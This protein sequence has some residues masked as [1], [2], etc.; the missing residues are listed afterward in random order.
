[1]YVICG[2][3][4]GINI[5]CQNGSCTIPSH[6]PTVIP[7]DGN[8]NMNT[9]PKGRPKKYAEYDQLVASLPTV[10]TKRPKYIRGIGVF[11]GKRDETAWIKI[12]L[13]HGGTYGGK[14]YDAGSSLEI[15]LGNLSSFSWKQLEERHNEMQGRADR[16]EALEDDAPVLFDEWAK[17]WLS[18]SEVRA[19]S[20]GTLKIH[21][22]KHFIPVFG[23]KALSDITLTDING[24]VTK[25]LKSHEPGT[26]KR[27][28]NTL[29]AIFN[30]AIKHEHLEKN[31]CQHVQPI[32]GIVARQ[33]FLDQ[34][35]VLKL[36][37]A[38]EETAV[39]LPDFILWCLHSGMRKGEI[40]ALTWDCVRKVDGDRSIVEVRNSKSDQPRMVVCTRTMKEII[41][42]Q[43]ARKKDG[44]DL[45]FPIAKMTLRRKW[46]KARKK[47]E[48]EDVTIHDLRRTNATQAV[49]AGIDLRTIAGRIGH[50]DLNML[51]KHYAALVGSASEG[52]AAKIQ[53]MFDGMM[54][55]KGQQ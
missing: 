55:N 18:R 53:D 40:V 17:N 3:G 21:V 14:R 20:P 22:E 34:E 6:I 54:N 27:Q 52:A 29:R 50:K 16:N 2:D 10:M 25:K 24:F 13:P 31:P 32:R 28:F 1:M 48:L 7:T 51:E 8:G 41:E 37:V 26:V 12:R 45:L 5:A 36:L 33:R 42:R 30:D 38:A 23:A 15:K 39:W 43:K 46:E 4:V 49:V 47:A 11:R 44:S 9:L 19:K 35:E